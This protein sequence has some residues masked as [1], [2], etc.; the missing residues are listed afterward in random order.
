MTTPNQSRAPTRHRLRRAALGTLTRGIAHAMANPLNA[1]LINA[2]LAKVCLGSAED[3]DEAALA[4]DAIVNET[5]RLATLLAEVHRFARSDDFSPDGSGT[6]A[7]VFEK[8]RGLLGSDL[9][10][11]SVDLRFEPNDEAGSLNLD[12]SGL[13][14]VLGALLQDSFIAGVRSMVVS[15][16]T[17]PS[18]ARILLSLHAPETSHEAWGGIDLDLLEQLAVDHGGTVRAERIEA[19]M[20]VTIEWPR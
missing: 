6:I 18:H 11:K 20:V 13:A 8:A 2:E 19:Q 5:K 1:V 3:R 4:L 7:Q 10:R 14:I 17:D 9:H 12:V 16:D 15:D